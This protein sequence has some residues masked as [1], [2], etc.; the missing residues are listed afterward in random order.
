SSAQ[1]LEESLMLTGDL[2][3]LDVRW[4]VQFKIKDSV[5]LLFAIRDP[6]DAIRDV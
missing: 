2:N 5:K 4:I 3:I 6:Q 1:Y